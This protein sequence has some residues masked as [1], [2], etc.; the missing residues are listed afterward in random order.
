[1]SRSATTPR[2][3]L[4]TRRQLPPRK[5]ERLPRR[6]W[7]SSLGA[8]SAGLFG[9]APHV[10]HHVGFLAGTALVAG[11][12]GTAVFAAL[13]LAVSTPM[14]LRLHRRFRTWKA[15]A[16]ALAVFAVM[17]ALSALVIGPAISGESSTT[18]PAPAVD[19][20]SHH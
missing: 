11:S 6:S 8:A 12:G 16:I 17:F 20:S 9:L 7:R 18:P 2:P 1:M 4:D 3:A 14:L 10:L 5:Q 19:H 15:P 13:G